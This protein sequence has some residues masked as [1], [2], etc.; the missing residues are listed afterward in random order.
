MVSDIPTFRIRR[1]SLNIRSALPEAL[2]LLSEE[3]P[4]YPESEL[5]LNLPRRKRN[6]TFSFVFHQKNLLHKGKRCE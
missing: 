1:E 3:G 4:Q 6:T 2:D 5:P